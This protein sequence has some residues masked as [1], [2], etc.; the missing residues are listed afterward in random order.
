MKVKLV[1]VLPNVYTYSP[2]VFGCVCYVCTPIIVHCS[3]TLN[4]GLYKALS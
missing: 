3:L 2:A 4:T 1:S